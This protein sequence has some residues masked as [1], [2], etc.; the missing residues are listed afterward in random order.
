M[1][2]QTEV[3]C[4]CLRRSSCLRSHGYHVCRSPSRLDGPIPFG[5][6][7]R[8]Y[9]PGNLRRSWS[10]SYDPFA[11]PERQRFG[12]TPNDSSRKNGEAL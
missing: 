8:D 11:M 3:D 6:L 1:R 12:G 4:G 7:F 9:L 2:R 10:G 5:I